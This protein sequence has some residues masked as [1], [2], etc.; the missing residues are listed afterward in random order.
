MELS[1]FRIAGFGGPL[2]GFKVGRFG[3]SGFETRQMLPEG[4][5]KTCRARGRK[6]DALK[7]LNR[8]SLVNIVNP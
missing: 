5:F 2:G 4:R 1:G 7:S 8:I 6:P 3:V